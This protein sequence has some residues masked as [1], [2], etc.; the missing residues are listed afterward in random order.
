MCFVARQGTI[1]LTDSD[2]RGEWFGLIMVPERKV[3]LASDTLLFCIFFDLGLIQNNS[4]SVQDP[5]LGGSGPCG[6]ER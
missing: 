4:E 5:L 1:Y 3:H 2:T 6:S